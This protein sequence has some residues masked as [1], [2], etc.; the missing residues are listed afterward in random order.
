MSMETVQKSL[1]I[2]K[3]I[4]RAIQESAE[5]SGKDFSSVTN[6]LLAEAVKVRRCPGILFAD[7]PS[8]RRARIAGTGID[9]WEGI[10]AYHGVG[11]KWARLR[12]SYHWLSEAQLRAALGYF[13]AYP[14]EID[15]QITRNEAWTKERL[16]GRHPTLAADGF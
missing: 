9:V 14:D 5:S 1:R 8:G 2:Q 6:E 4:A 7:G 13:T 11:R 10:D 15:R 12:K 3:D 16:A